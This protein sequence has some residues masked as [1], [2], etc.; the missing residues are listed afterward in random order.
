MLFQCFY[1]N[2]CVYL[3]S[4]LRSHT[5]GT[6]NEW[7]NSFMHSVSLQLIWQVWKTFKNEVFLMV[8]VITLLTT[9]SGFLAL[10]SVLEW[11]QTVRGR[12]WFIIKGTDRKITRKRTSTTNEQ[13]EKLALNSGC[14]TQT[15]GLVLKDSDLVYTAAVCKILKQP[16]QFRNCKYEGNRYFCTLF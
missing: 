3:V 4:I 2:V 15:K 11:V 1:L 14:R 16:E 10:T 7:Q 8:A 9:V 12:Y 5:G 13:H 6:K